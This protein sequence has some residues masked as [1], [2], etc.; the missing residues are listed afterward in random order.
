MK[1]RVLFNNII[2]L[3]LKLIIICTSIIFLSVNE[4]IILITLLFLVYIY[5]D[6]ADN[7]K[8][9][10]NYKGIINKLDKMRLGNLSVAFEPQYN[11]ALDGIIESLNLV[12]ESF[13]ESLILANTDSEEL[14]AASVNLTIITEELVRAI[15]IISEAAHEIAHNANEIGNIS[16]ATAECS[17]KTVNLSKQI[18]NEMSVVLDFSKQSNRSS[19]EG[20][21]S[22]EDATKAIQ[23]AATTIKNNTELAIQLGDKSEQVQRIVQTVNT[24]ASQTNLL[25]LN[26]SIEAAR[27]GVYGASFSVVADEVKKLAE[28]SQGAAKQIEGIITKMLEEINEVVKMMEKTTHVITDGS[29]VIEKAN[30]SFKGIKTATDATLKHVENVTLMINHQDKTINKM[31][32]FSHNLKDISAELSEETQT[33]AAGSLEIDSSS[34][35]LAEDAKR[36]SSIAGELQRNMLNFQFTDQKIIRVAFGMTDQSPSYKGMLKF[37]ELVD[38]YSKGSYKVKIFH[39]SQLGGDIELIKKLQEGTLEM[40]FPSSS[41]VSSYDPNFM[42]LDFPFI[43][44]DAFRA[45][46]VLN[47]EFGDRLL[48]SLY[49]RGLK[50]LAFAENGYRE[51][52]TSKKPIKSIEDFN[53]LKLRTMENQVHMDVFKA[54]GAIPVPMPFGQIYNSLKYN[55][56]DGQENSLPTIFSAGFQEVQKY[57][58][59][60]H[61]V[62]GLLVLMYSQTHWDKLPVD[63]QGFIQKA[64]I[65][66]AEYTTKINQIQTKESLEKLKQANITINEIN[67]NE[68]DRIKDISSSI[69]NKYR[70]EVDLE[71]FEA[72]MS[73]I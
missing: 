21:K 5:F 49:S 70:R 73:S 57:L 60:S 9:K 43:F 53:S 19:I 13:R 61:H 45:F 51:I 4:S 37:A 54:L 47:G 25:A 30:I 44:K 72:F 16:L 29:T 38:H 46:K 7:R 59:L 10:E 36:L 18:K 24:I 28:Q 64:A 33:A 22:I 26:A 1:K 67:E 3:V 31:K 12:V 71:L 6:I 68:F 11:N 41:N 50:G 2:F 27:A 56:V 55:A 34:L 35:S 32:N 69:L 23:G 17:D 58:T 52:T 39:S 20:E 65:E 66:A 48:N 63:V 14:S 40:C 15:S 42:L 62:Y 8:S